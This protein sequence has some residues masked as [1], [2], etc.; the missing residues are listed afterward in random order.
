[1]HEV[2]ARD[3]AVD[4]AVL[5]V[6]GHVGG[7]DEEHVDRRVAAREGECAVARLLRAEAGVLEQLDR[8]LPEPTRRRDRDLQA[9][10][11][12]TRRRGFAR[13]RSSASRYPSSPW[14]SQCATRVTVA[15][16]APVRFATS[17]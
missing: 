11:C 9:V 1:V 3:P 12:A 16:D 5:N 8:R 13:S 4:D 14:R 7:A 6:L 17:W 15:V 10:G 2:E